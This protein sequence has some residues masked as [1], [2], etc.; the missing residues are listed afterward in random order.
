MIDDFMLRA[1]LAGVGV[2][3][4]T[5]PLGC[6]V[7]WQRLAMFGNSVAHCGLLG[8]AVGVLLSIDLTLG[9]IMTS[10]ALAVPVCSPPPG[11][12]A[13]VLT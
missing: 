9:V 2:A 1:G 13:H 8:V 3:L 7:V 12:A 10:V 5:A 6:F 11:S 4:L